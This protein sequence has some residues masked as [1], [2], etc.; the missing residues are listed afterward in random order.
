MAMSAY[1]DTRVSLYASRLWPS[2]EVEALIGAPDDA[3]AVALSRR[4]LPQ[5]AP[6]VAGPEPDPRSLEQHI[7]AQTLDETRV[8]LRP[9]SGAERAFLSFWI[10]RFEISNVKTLLRSKMTG[11]RPSAVLERLTPMGPF[12]LLDDQELAHAEDVGELLR[13]LEAG[14]YAGIIRHARRAFEETGD[15]FSLDAALD[16]GYYEG[17]AARARPLE[18]RLG[19]SFRRLMADLIDRINL[20]WLLRYRFNYGLPPAQVYYLLVRAPYGLSG[21][22]LGQLAARESVAGVLEALPPTWRTRLAGAADISTIHAR[23]DATTA[24]EALRVLGSRAP[25]LARAFAYLVLRERDLRFLRS[26][27][28]G[29]YLGLMPDAI[30]DVLRQASAEAA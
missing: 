2:G 1:L 19:G 6:G 27:L 7:V 25:A 4:G 5:L 20:G 10:V 8:L 26:L 22:R 14:P 12:G 18:E 29:R 16:R 21:P 9:L 28:R 3:I 11:E 15:P 30:R 13:R 24:R 17:L 23:I